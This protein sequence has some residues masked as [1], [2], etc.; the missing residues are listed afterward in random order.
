MLG[1][2]NNHHTQNTAPTLVDKPVKKPFSHIVG[3]V[4][5]GLLLVVGLFVMAGLLQLRQMPIRFDIPICLPFIFPVFFSIGLYGLIKGHKW[6]R[7]FCSL[8]SAF[9][10]VLFILFP[11]I[12][13]IGSK[14]FCPDLFVGVIGATLLSWW[15]YSF[16]FGKKSKEYFKI[17]IDLSEGCSKPLPAP[18]IL[19][20]ERGNHT[21][22]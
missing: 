8:P 3:I 20:A 7:I 2:P 15:L 1:N 13:G 18:D 5:Y 14:Q 21:R 16:F 12:N 9:F 22:L 10:I 17:K 6:S 19:S 4:L 11:F